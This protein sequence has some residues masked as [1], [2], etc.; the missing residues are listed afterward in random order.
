MNAKTLTAVALL[1][2][3]L[4]AASFAQGAPA[5]PTPPTLDF[6]TADADGSGG[7]SAEEWTAYSATLHTEMRAQRMAARA[8]ALIAAGDA[9]GDTALDRDELIAAMTAQ[10]D[11]RREAR[12]EGRGRMGA[13]M[14]RHHGGE[15]HGR[16]GRGGER[17][18]MRGERGGERREMR[19]ERG[20]DR[21]PRAMSGEHSGGGGFTR[22]DANDDGQID[23][24]ELAHAQEMINW[25]AQRPVRN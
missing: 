16:W 7:I 18:E 3:A 13:M 12:G 5:R 17:G 6:A 9:N 24:Q 2:A 4:P 22:I 11:E 14:A 10:A 8:D 15:D 23:A 21:G 19:G 20:G 1:M 25:M